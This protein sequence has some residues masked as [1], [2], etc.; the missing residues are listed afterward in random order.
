MDLYKVRLALEEIDRDVKSLIGLRELITDAM[1]AVENNSLV[2]NSYKQEIALKGY[3]LIYDSY[4][5]P[6]SPYID[7]IYNSRI[8]TERIYGESDSLIL[9]LG[10][11]GDWQ[12]FELGTLL[13]SLSHLHNV[14]TLDRKLR[15]NNSDYRYKK[16]QTRYSVINKAKVHYYLEKNEELKIKQL[17][18]SSPGIID[19][20]TNNFANG[21]YIAAVLISIHQLPN[22]LNKVMTLWFKY[23]KEV[24]SVRKLEREDRIDE[25]VSQFIDREIKNHLINN[26]IDAEAINEIMQGIKNISVNNK[27]ARSD[28]LL[29]KTLH[30]LAVL[31]N[32]DKREKYHVVR[33]KENQRHNE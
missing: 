8:G 14:A 4:V 15:S 21:S 29:E 26:E 31:S 13:G 17:H 7:N 3:M 19:F 10:L 30:S 5:R 11:K 28:V 33:K 6:I 20:I 32:L 23:K 25:L 24:L 16:G 9:T 2:K 27:L 22:F 18:I 1:A 12:S